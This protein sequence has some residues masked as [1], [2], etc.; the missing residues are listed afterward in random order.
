M[1]T[2]RLPGLRSKFAQ[3]PDR[4][5]CAAN[6]SRCTRHTVRRIRK[7]SDCARTSCIRVRSRVLRN[8]A[9]RLSPRHRIGT[10]TAYF[11]QRGSFGFFLQSGAF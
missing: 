11:G 2:E 7:V 1:L 4:I 8:P 3:C 5:A 10:S 9:M 6:G